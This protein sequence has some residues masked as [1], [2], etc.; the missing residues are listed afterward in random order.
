MAT[1]GFY[2]TNTLDSSAPEIRKLKITNI[3]ATTKMITWQTDEPS[4]SVLQYGLNT[5]Y[6]LSSPIE[7]AFDTEHTVLVD[8]LIVAPADSY[9]YQLRARDMVEMSHSSEE[10]FPESLATVMTL[11]R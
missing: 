4:I 6:G 7:G 9:V 5:M 8:D 10:I 1:A 3:N 11:R 2:G